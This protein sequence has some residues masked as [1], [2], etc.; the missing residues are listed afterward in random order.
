M[1]FYHF[2]PQIPSSEE[3]SFEKLKENA[4]NQQFKK[5]ACVYKH[6]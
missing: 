6:G 4:C 2:I 3:R 5:N 1:L